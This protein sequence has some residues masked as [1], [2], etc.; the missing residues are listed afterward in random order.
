ML[1]G[2]RLDGNVFVDLPPQLDEGAVGEVAVLE[3]LVDTAL[4]RG[5]FVVAHSRVSHQTTV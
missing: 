3:S 4:T 5:V 2:R 1:G